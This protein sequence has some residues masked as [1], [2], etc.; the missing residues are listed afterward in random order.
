MNLKKLSSFL[1]GVLMLFSAMPAQAAVDSDDNSSNSRTSKRNV[2]L[3]DRYN[4]LLDEIYGNKDNIEILN[5][6][7]REMKQEI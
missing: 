2:K 7:F 3:A 4:N 1:L 5:R 6:I